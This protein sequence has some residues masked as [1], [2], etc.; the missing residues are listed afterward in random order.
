MGV[1]TKGSRT[2]AVRGVLFGLAALAAGIFGGAP[3]AMALVPVGTELGTGMQCPNDVDFAPYNFSKT[4]NNPNQLPNKD[5]YDIDHNGNGKFDFD[6]NVVC[7]RLGATDGY[8]KMPGANGEDESVY[9]FGF[10]E[11]FERNPDE[12]DVPQKFVFTK[13]ENQHNSGGPPYT[14]PQLFDKRFHATLPAPTVRI[15]KGQKLYLTVTNVGVYVRPDLDDPHTLHFHGFRN[16]SAAFD[17]VPELSWAVPA[18][19]SST[20]YFYQVEHEGTY[21][22]HCHVE[23]TEHIG[24]GMVGTLVV[25]AEIPG[26]VY[27]PVPEG[28]DFSFDKEYVLHVHDVD[29]RMSHNLETVQEGSNKWHDW[30]PNFFTLNGRVYPETLLPDN[31]PAMLN[32]ASEYFEDYI[33]QPYSSLITAN[34]GDRILLRLQNLT[35]QSQSFTVP[36]IPMHV[37]G[38]DA[39]PLV[40]PDGSDISFKRVAYN[41]LGGEEADVILDTTNVPPGTYWLYARELYSQSAVPR[42]LKETGSHEGNYVNRGLITRID[43]Q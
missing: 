37:V 4:P 8:L 17:G 42:A 28:P 23:P 26:Y 2:L 38:E 13:E 21:A 40:G 35:Y 29:S 36:G 24:M 31:D 27:D 1:N 34:A 22:Y 6:P 18:G 14:G 39:T 5:D 30:T 43:L 41:I 11:L 15:R 19:G 10:M 20:T 9:T 32:H 12:P 7:W 16:A 25:E 3:A 33:A